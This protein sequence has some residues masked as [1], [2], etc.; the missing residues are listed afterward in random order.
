MEWSLE[1]KNPK[2]V[3]SFLTTIHL[4]LKWRK[5]DTQMMSS[6]S[7]LPVRMDFLN[8]PLDL[9][10]ALEWK[11]CSECGARGVV[12]FHTLS[13]SNESNPIQTGS[14]KWR[15]LVGSCK[16][17]ASGM[18]ISDIVKSFFP[19]SLSLSSFL[20][21]V[22]SFFCFQAHFSLMTL[23][24]TPTDLSF[25][26]NASFCFNK[27][28]RIELKWTGVFIFVRN[29]RVK[30]GCSRGKFKMLY[31]KNGEVARLAKITNIHYCESGAHFLR[32]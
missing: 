26:S 1:K 8:V 25:I 5:F 32:V 3:S 12:V 10:V 31:Q 24:L 17:K 13:L 19:F 18:S 16:T 22:S 15:G 23:W 2:L 11:L 29:L 7:P 28:S 4:I 21:N 6:Y 20:S 30:E 14:N 27:K 9:T